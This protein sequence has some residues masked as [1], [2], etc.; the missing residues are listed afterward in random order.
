MTDTSGLAPAL[1]MAM[2]MAPTSAGLVAKASEREMIARFDSKK[3]YNLMVWLG[4]E[5]KEVAF[6]ARALSIHSLSMDKASTHLIELDLRKG[7]I[8]LYRAPAEE[9]TFGLNLETFVKQFVRRSERVELRCCPRSD[10]LTLQYEDRALHTFC[11]AR[12]PLYNFSGYM[13]SV[14]EANVL[15][16]AR[17]SVVDWKLAMDACKGSG[18]DLA[19]FQVL[20][21]KS[22]NNRTRLQLSCCTD[23]GGSEVSYQFGFTEN[24][25][26]KT[27]TNVN[28]DDDNDEGGDEAPLNVAGAKRKNGSSS[29]NGT[30]KRGKA[31]AEQQQTFQ[32]LDVKADMERLSAPNANERF[33]FRFALKFVAYLVNIRPLSSEFQLKLCTS[34]GEVGD[35]AE[36]LKIDFDV[37]GLGS[38]HAGLISRIRSDS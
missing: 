21:A 38:V 2:D 17:M 20:L 28:E 25:E 5:M 13:G 23:S 33:D 34:K 6:T 19:I 26:A 1:Q 4:T 18:L 37:E 10:A 35:G 3:F 31:D 16:S 14:P 36:L 8:N 9:F 27:H 29:T 24:K 15:F 32:M 11:R 30:K 7:F 22:P 12:T